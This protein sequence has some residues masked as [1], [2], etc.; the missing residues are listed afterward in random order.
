MTSPADR[1]IIVGAGPAGCAAAIT[2]ANDGTRATMLEASRETGDAICGGFLSWQ[3]LERARQLGIDPAS[4]GGHK[5]TQVRLFAGERRAAARLPQPGLGLSRH[6]LDSDLMAHAIRVGVGV[7]RGVRVRG[8]DAA[9]ATTRDGAT[10]TGGAVMLAT[11]KYAMRGQDR[12]PPQP[13]ASDPVVGL[14]LRLPPRPELQRLVNDAVELFLFDGGYAGLVLQ[15]DGSAN[16]CLA[17]HKSQLIRCGGSPAGLIAEWARHCGPLGDRIGTL[18]AEPAV[19]AIAAIPYGW[20]AQSSEDGIWRVGDQAACI[21]SLAG[22]GMGIALASGQ[23]AARALVAGNGAATWQ[24]QMARRL[25]RP[26]LVARGVW[27]VTEQPDRAEYALRLAS[28]MPFTIAAIA[29]LTRVPT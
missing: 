13:A 14:R 20:M 1:P 6:R 27:H 2:L 7:E 19:D 29:R 12:V 21:P 5:V 10:L 15:E 25:R 11:G 28:R 8:V 23:S 4:L 18:P 17:V 22:E 3:A 9:T 16:L 24:R 26:M